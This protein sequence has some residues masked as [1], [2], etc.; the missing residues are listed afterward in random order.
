M[1]CCAVAAAAHSESVPDEEQVISRIIELGTSDN[2]VKEH[3][4]VLNNRFGGRL[5]GSDAYK[6]AATGLYASMASGA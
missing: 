3:L 2:R 4:D 6:N 1:A 5:V